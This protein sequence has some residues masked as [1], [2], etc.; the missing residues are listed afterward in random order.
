MT[1][2]NKLRLALGVV[3]LLHLALRIPGLSQPYHQDEYKWAQ[4]VAVGSPTAGTIPHPPLSELIYT[5]TDRVF[6]NG[7]LRMTPF[8]FSILN[9]GLIFLVARKR[10]GDKT[11]LI[12]AGLFS[13]SFYSILA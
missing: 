8:L 11:A 9:L 10:Y 2:K 4:I 6:G 1:K 5:I 7:H 13:A 3:L 12:A